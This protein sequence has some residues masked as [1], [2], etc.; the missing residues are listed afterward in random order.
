MN[1]GRQPQPVT[2]TILGNKLDVEYWLRILRNRA[3]SSGDATQA[4][5]QGEDVYGAVVGFK[6]FPR[7]V[8]D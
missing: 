1:F 3:E 4:T 6:I 5:T 7:A 2:V 8:N